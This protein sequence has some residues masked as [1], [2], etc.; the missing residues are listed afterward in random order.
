MN[1]QII[2]R[3]IRKPRELNI[4]SDINW[5]CDSF[6]LSTGRDLDKLSNQVVQSLLKGISAKGFASSFDIAEDIH[7]NIQRVN[8][9]LRT[10]AETG[11]IYRDKRHILLRGNSLKETIEEIRNDANRIFD[12]LTRI[13]EDIDKALG[14]KSRE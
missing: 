10:L 14:L 6:G 1:R 11:F 4:V 13:A 9:H 3:N 8:Y 5:V 12:E 7:A 2:L